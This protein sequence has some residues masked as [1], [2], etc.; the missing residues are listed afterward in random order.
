M[1]KTPGKLFLFGIVVLSF[2]QF[3]HPDNAFAL[4]AKRFDNNGWSEFGGVWPGEDGGYYLWG[5]TSNPSEPQATRKTYL[6]LSKLN[7]SGVPQW[8]R[9]IY[10]GDY[11]NLSIHDLGG[12][13]FFVQGTTQTSK[14]GL[15]DVI[16][17]KFT[18]NSSTGDFTPVFQKIFRGSGDDS[19]AFSISE[20]GDVIIGTGSTNSFSGD[21]D[22]DD[23]LIIKIDPSSGGRV[24]SKVFDHGLEDQSPI[25]LEV[26]DGYMLCSSVAN[27]GSGGADILVA[28]LNATGDPQWVKLYGGTRKNNAT[29]HK[30]SGGNYLLWG[31]TQDV[32]NPLD[33]DLLLIKIDGS[34][35]ILWGKKYASDG[36]DIVHNIIENADGTFILNGTIM[37]PIASNSKILLMKIKADGTIEWKKTLGGGRIDFGTFMKMPDGNY[38]LT[39]SSTSFGSSAS[40][41]DALFGKFDSDFTPQWVRTFGGNR[42][43][44]G[45][46]YSVSNQFVLTGGTDSFSP[47]PGIMDVYG[48]TL[49]SDGEFPGCSYI[50]NVTL[51]PDNDPSITTSNLN[52]TPTPTVL[53]SRVHTMTP[54]S[55]SLQ[56]DSFTLTPNDICTGTIEEGTLSVTP[57]E[58]PNFSGTQGGP[59][60]PTY[61]YYNLANTG[62]TSI[63][64]TA[65][66]TQNWVT[67]SKSNGTLNPG[68]STTVSVA[69]NSNANSFAPGTYNDTVTFANTTNHI[70]D[71]QK[72]L[73]LIVNAPTP[74]VLSVTPIEGI[75]SIGTQ[76]GPFNPNQQSYKLE[77]TGGSRIDWSVT[78][79]EAWINLSGASGFLNAGE[80]THVVVSINNN[81][82]SL[83]PG[84][85][86]DPVNFSN[87]TNDNGSTHRIVNLTVNAP[88]PGVLSVT[89]GDLLNASGNQ[90]G[91]FSPVSKIYTI[92]NT[93]GSSIIWSASKTLGWVTLSSAG[94]TLTAGASTTVTVSINASVANGLAPGTY[95]DTVTFTNGSTNIT[96][97]VSLTVSAIFLTLSSPSNG[98]NFGACSYYTPEGPPTFQWNTNG[99]F[100]SI[101]VQFSAQNDFSTNLVKAKGKPGINQIQ[102]TSSLWKKI[103]LLPG[104]TGGTGY[105]RVVGTKADKTKVGE[106]G[107]F[108]FSVEGPKAIG[109]LQIS[110]T[111]RLALTP[112]TL[113]W[114]NNC[115]LTFK[116]WFG[117]DSDFSKIGMKKKSFSF[118]VTNPNDNGGVFEKVLTPGQWLTIRKLVLDKSGS[119]LHWYVEASD[120][121]KR[122]AQK[123]L[124]SDFDLVD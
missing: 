87:T 103:L 97:G 2:L 33:M 115:N 14:S 93:G 20:S 38:L 45:M 44:N 37:D 90:G 77:N 105:W 42:S 63:N 48:I 23:M 57:S 55:I 8:S 10:T 22:D 111:H 110:H 61:Q 119:T 95:N 54:A 11:D 5:S 99:A 12:G 70:G 113:S 34:G 76:G 53:V 30:I 7:S 46:I 1:F 25:V 91:P 24:W 83:G 47:G 56:I 65:T 43:D 109:N 116:V 41:Y 39:G 3:S 62:T 6:I 66:K 68:D 32:M 75:N 64:W 18:V 81:A 94:G 9:K 102:I 123:T 26:S 92:K 106:G 69:I 17:A 89:P 120:V 84:E 100:K 80:S 73:A 60:T 82:N 40:D 79:K 36:M 28:K 13:H 117:N 16:W 49:N 98:Q 78:K 59:F 107:F 19:L 101:E 72:G 122:P 35:N 124:G 118:K 15:S 4:W 51:T 104:L 71:T 108:S 121:L 31:T 96:R 52:W 67:L 88:P 86:Y 21:P 29:I 27:A 114:E 58:P 112:P 74:G 50:K 85:Y